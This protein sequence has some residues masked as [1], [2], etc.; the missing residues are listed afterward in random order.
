MARTSAIC[1]T[2]LN[3]NRYDGEPV[4]LDFM[5]PKDP[6]EPKAEYAPD[7]ITDPE[8]KKRIFQQLFG[9]DKKND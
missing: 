1:A 6:D 2:I 8:E 7:V 4:P 5:V 9:G 3:V